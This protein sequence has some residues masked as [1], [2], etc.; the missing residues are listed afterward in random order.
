MSRQPQALPITSSNLGSAKAAEGAGG[1]VRKSSWL[2]RLGSGLGGRPFTSLWAGGGPLSLHGLHL[3]PE[4]DM[5][6]V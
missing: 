6:R 5:K 4:E 2:S 1:R 3:E